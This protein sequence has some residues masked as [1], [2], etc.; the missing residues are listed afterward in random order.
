MEM[1]IDFIVNCFMDVLSMSNFPCIFFHELQ[2]PFSL[3]G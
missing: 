1:I 3:K 2:F